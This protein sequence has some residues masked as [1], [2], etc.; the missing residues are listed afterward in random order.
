MEGFKCT[1]EYQKVSWSVFAHSEFTLFSV[2]EGQTRDTDTHDFYDGTVN[3]DI[4]AETT[5][6]HSTVWRF[7]ILFHP[8][9]GTPEG[10][11]LAGYYGLTQI[12]RSCFKI[13]IFQLISHIYVSGCFVNFR[14]IFWYI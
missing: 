11:I 14:V 13:K 3:F 4:P 6:T 9:K 1:R 8:V 2:K 10:R 12:S 7:C 5:T